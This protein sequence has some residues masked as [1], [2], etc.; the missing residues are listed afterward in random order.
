MNDRE[1]KG[2]IAVLEVEKRAAQKHLTVS[3]PTLPARYDLILDDNGL[4]R[5]Q[6]K[7]SNEKSAHASGSFVVGLRRHG[8]RY[9]EHEIDFL[10]VY[11]PATGKVYK[12]PIAIFAGHESITLRIQPTRNGQK[13]RIF[14]AN[15][16]EW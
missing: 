4:H 7:Y 16:Y 8:Y 13:K 5:V 14:Y 15:E 6:V 3:V 2:R 1:Y 12:L 10:M 9:A 11:L